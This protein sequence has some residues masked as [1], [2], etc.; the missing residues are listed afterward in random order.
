MSPKAGGAALALCALLVAGN[1]V[2]GPAA[3][4][5]R[6][7]AEVALEVPQG[8]YLDVGGAVELV[9]GSNVQEVPEPFAESGGGLVLGYLGG[10]FPGWTS[11]KLQRFEWGNANPVGLEVDLAP[12]LQYDTWGNT[13]A[14]GAYAALDAADRM[15]RV[16][17]S[18]AF[19]A[20]AVN[21][22]V[23]DLAGSTLVADRRVGTTP[24]GTASA[25]VA[26]G[27]NA[28]VHV[29]RWNTSLL[30]SRMAANGS[31]TATNLTLY[32]DGGTGFPAQLA[33]D[34]P[35]G[36]MLVAWASR[37]G[38]GYVRALNENGSAAWGPV[39]LGTTAANLSV[40]AV[41]D[42]G[43]VAVWS[44]GASV[45]AVKLNATGGV[46]LADRVVF[47]S[48]PEAQTPRPVLLPSG[49]VLV[50]WSSA[51]GG[52]GLKVRAGALDAADL[53]VV[54]AA[55][56]VSLGA[57]S[58]V[59]AR[60][61]AAPDG[62][63]WVV[64]QN[65]TGAYTSTIWGAPLRLRW[66]GYRVAVDAPDMTLIRG[67]VGSVP[68]AFASLSPE[69]VNLSVGAVVSVG[70]GPTNW[71]AGVVNA[72]TGAPVADLGLEAGE[73][74]GLSL[75]VRGPVFDPTPYR[76][77]VRVQVADVHRPSVVLD[78]RVNVT[79]VA[80][81]RFQVDPADQ[82]VT[83]WP[84]ATA[85]LTFTVRN[86]GLADEQG[87]PL[88]LSVPP[89]DPAWSAALSAA[90]FT[91]PRGASQ[92]VVL[93]VTPPVDASAGE[94]YCG[95]L[96]VQNPNDVFSLATAGFC[97]RVGL[98][99][100]PVVTPDFQAV[101]VDP[102]GSTRPAFAML[103]EGNAGQ[104]V[105]CTLGLVES[106]PSGWTVLGSPFGARLAG[107]QTAAASFEVAAPGNAPGGQVLNLTVRGTCAGS[108][109]VGE[110][111]V[112]ITVRSVHS[113]AWRSQ[114]TAVDADA[115]G[116]ASFEFTLENM[117]NVGEAVEVEVV[118]SPPGFT[119][120]SALSVGGTPAEEV[121]AFGQGK[122]ALRVQAPAEAPSGSYQLTVRLRAGAMD[123][124]NLSLTVRL[125]AA[126]GLEAAFNASGLDVGPSG[127]VGIEGALRHLGNVRDIFVVTVR[128]DAP[129]YWGV[130]MRYERGDS[131]DTS[132][133]GTGT[134]T[135]APYARGRLLLEITAPREPVPVSVPVTVVLSSARGPTA[136]FATVV[137]VVLPDLTVTVESL[138]QGFADPELAGEVVL[139]VANA[140]QAASAP[141]GLR[142]LVDG[143]IVLV[144][145]VPSVGPG[146]SVFLRVP[147]TLK[148]GAHALALFVDPKDEPG[149]SPVVGRVYESDEYN[150][151]ARVNFVVEER[152]PSE[153]APEAA[154]VT[155]SP[156]ASMGL[157]ALVPILAGAGAAL[158]LLGRQR[159]KRPKV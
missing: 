114:G 2:T 66:T 13:T 85:N 108:V 20:Q 152:P 36:L 127:V 101:E 146:L 69:A 118:A 41:G 120:E 123:P 15:A 142:V 151:E 30:Y 147:L 28:S 35:A 129:Q 153:P 95:R 137:R 16:Y 46:E 131:N 106:L 29:V 9:S 57:E 31:W 60:A 103:N 67:E 138:P 72:T 102:G 125:P 116:A 82:N 70:A 18:Y 150:N 144:D 55:S 11:P 132:F 47:A 140:G 158:F 157:L 71:T 156:P 75:E 139:R 80:G 148:A 62:S 124:W 121:P 68:L 76:A 45:H 97:V 135:L 126:Y 64:W 79:V 40:G 109:A 81:H 21:V 159:R 23:V 8:R 4:G 49:E 130:D 96:K 56:S 42:G 48:E 44:D 65:D 33:Y 19:P 54:A 115:S 38:T 27:A 93:A 43:V 88:A 154:P 107:G 84:G 110:A 94:S 133:L 37:A 87:V 32:S 111:R 83:A 24:Y 100:R 113:A 74:A 50:V 77:V 6:E 78:L 39:S 59:N 25:A 119:V 61:A 63:V 52:G 12:G 143:S 91:A 14:R 149:A 7:A 112:E 105:D 117:G 145:E 89:F 51:A 98:V 53:S 122:V 1:L 34:R 73:S 10:S 155:T 99:A 104:P 26:V 17:W 22:K 92:A 134:L 128:V 58:D 86:T 90:D 5:G 141:T 136:S 3:A